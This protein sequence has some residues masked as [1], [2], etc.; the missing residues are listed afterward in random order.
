VEPS[1]QRRRAREV[2][3]PDGKLVVA[4]SLLSARSGFSAVTWVSCSTSRRAVAREL[5]V[6]AIAGFTEG[7]ELS[8]VEQ[9]NRLVP[10]LTK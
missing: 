7:A 8:E 9:A 4:T 2:T 3:E 6:P 10:D 5:L 1:R